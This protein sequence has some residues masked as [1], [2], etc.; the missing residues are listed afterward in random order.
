[1]ESWSLNQAPECSY[2]WPLTIGTKEEIM[3]N[4]DGTLRPHSECSNH[5]EEDLAVSH[6]GD[7]ETTFYLDVCT[8]PKLLSNKL[9]KILFEHSPKQVKKNLIFCRW[10]S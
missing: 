2:I 10:K 7:A 9:I 5:S 6:C 3:N 8:W 1:M 4:A